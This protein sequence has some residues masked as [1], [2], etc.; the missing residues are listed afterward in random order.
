MLV[1]KVSTDSIRVDRQSGE[2]ETGIVPGK[3]R[4]HGR[5]YKGR[6]PSSTERRGNLLYAAAH[7]A[8]DPWHFAFNFSFCALEARFLRLFLRQPTRA[9]GKRVALSMT[10]Q[11]RE[12]NARVNLFFS[13]FFFSEARLPLPSCSLPRFFTSTTNPLV[14]FIIFLDFFFVFLREGI[15]SNG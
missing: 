3:R 1:E 4:C 10:T 11:E 12:R 13:V 9:R 5:W 8:A 2:I 14:I 7:I 6:A 15:W